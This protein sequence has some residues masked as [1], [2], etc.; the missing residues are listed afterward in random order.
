MVLGREESLTLKI[1]RLRVRAGSL[2]RRLQKVSRANL[3]QPRAAAL[4]DPEVPNPVTEEEFPRLVQRTVW[5]IFER[6]G[7]TA[8]IPAEVRLRLLRRR[9]WLS[10]RRLE[11]L[12]RIQVVSLEEQA[13]SIERAPQKAN[14]GSLWEPEPDDASRLEKTERP[15]SS[16][17]ESGRRVWRLVL[18][19]T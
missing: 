16:S 15:I 5:G 11:L 6:L 18:P 1:R 7:A 19:L 2:G 10:G 17:W 13:R 8:H 14:L 9:L 12:S 4:C 3:K